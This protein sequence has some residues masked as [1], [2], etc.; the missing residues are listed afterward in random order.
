MNPRIRIVA[1]SSIVIGVA[2]VALTASMMI[3]CR[4]SL[5]IRPLVIG[6]FEGAFILASETCALDII[7]AQYVRDVENGEVVIF[8]E[9]GAQSH[10]PFPP[11]QARAGSRCWPATSSAPVRWRKTA[12][13]PVAAA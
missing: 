13:S 12:T 5:G 4:D 8:D 10:K 7:G 1:W 11:M 9:D 6:D 2:L 3:G